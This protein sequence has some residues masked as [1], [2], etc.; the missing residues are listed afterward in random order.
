M[1]AQIMD[2]VTYRDLLWS[3]CKVDF[4]NWPVP[5][6]EKIGIKCEMEST[7]NYSGRI[8]YFL[9]DRQN[10]LTFIKAQVNL[11]EGQENFIPTNGYR[12]EVKRIYSNKKMKPELTIFLGFPPIKLNYTGI[13]ELGRQFNL[14]KY[15]HIGIQSV[16]RFFHRMYLE[17]ENGNVIKEKTREEKG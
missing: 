15:K 9:I 14:E 16:D 5:S 8:N 11:S 17:F 7:A 1:T 3:L 2:S 6:N 10:R 12:E 13:M 4:D